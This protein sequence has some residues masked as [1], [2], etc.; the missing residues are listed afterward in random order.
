MHEVEEVFISVAIFKMMSLIH[1]SY[2]RISTGNREI[3]IHVRIKRQWISLG[4]YPAR[5]AYKYLIFSVW[6]DLGLSLRI[7]STWT[8]LPESQRDIHDLT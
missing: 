7:P 8:L 6:D 5:S 2:I 4:L 3:I 1:L